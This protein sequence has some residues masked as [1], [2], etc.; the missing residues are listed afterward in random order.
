LGADE[1]A[2]DAVI[3]KDVFPL[4]PLRSRVEVYITVR[5]ETALFGDHHLR[6]YKASLPALQGVTDEGDA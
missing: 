2:V 1:P 5:I 4:K 6:Q 3:Q